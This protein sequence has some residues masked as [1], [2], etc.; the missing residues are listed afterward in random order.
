M[1]MVEQAAKASRNRNWLAGWS[2]SLPVTEISWLA[3]RPRFLSTGVLLYL[4]TNS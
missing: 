3:P 2:I 4:Y 1:Q